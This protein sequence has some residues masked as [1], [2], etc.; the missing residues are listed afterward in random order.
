MD[1]F[2]SATSTG[3]GRSFI[4]LGI[5]YFCYM[6]FGSFIVRVPAE[7]WKPAGYQ[8]PTTIAR[9]D[10][11]RERDRRLRLANAAILAP[12]G[13][14]LFQRH[15]GHRYSR[16]GF[17]DDSG[18]VSGKVLAAAAGGF[19]ALLSLFNMGGRFLWSSFSDYIGRKAVY[20]IYLL[21]GTILYCLIPVAGR[22]G[23]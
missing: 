11:D 1:Y 23:A 21:L 12:L 3:V 7:D 6:M 8:P 2:K 15:R 19:V 16:A 9:I 20:V 5:I 13:C 4:A 18:N 14:P 10:H 17:A 22:V